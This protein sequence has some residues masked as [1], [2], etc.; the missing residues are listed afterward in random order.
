M[1]GRVAERVLAATF[2]HGRGDH[3]AVPMLPRLGDWYPS[4]RADGCVSMRST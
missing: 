4:E 3:T 1:V 2:A